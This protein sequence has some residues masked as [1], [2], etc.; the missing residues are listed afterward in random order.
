MLDM[1]KLHLFNKGIQT[2]TV[3]MY[4]I[5]VRELFKFAR[6]QG[7]SC[8][9]YEI[10]S[11]PK[12]SSTPH[13]TLPLDKF[14]KIIEATYES[15]G[16][17]VTRDRAILYMLF[18]CWLRTAE[19]LYMK[20]VDIEGDRVKVLW[21]W[22][23]I[24]ILFLVPSVVV[25]LQEYLE[26]RWSDGCEYLFVNRIRKSCRNHLSHSWLKNIIDTYAKKAWLGHIHPHQFR[27]GFACHLLEQGV[28][29]RTIQELLGHSSLLTTM[30][31]LSITEQQL[32]DA[33][34]ALKI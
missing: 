2:S 25:A 18:G 16:F 21:K 17:R 29:L 5:V 20:L 27:H 8:I 34:L 12:F 23:K 10:I 15:T 14:K 22:G 7:M 32:H 4:L 33:Q 6:I 11:L 19:L 9:D 26:V 28:G 3:A 13:D 30:R 24:R 31:Y 1:Y